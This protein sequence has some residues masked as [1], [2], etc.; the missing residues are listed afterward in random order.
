MAMR[1]KMNRR[2]SS[3]NFRRGRRVNG[4]NFA[5]AKRGGYRI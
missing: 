1:R 4:R 3:K 5:T 2:Q